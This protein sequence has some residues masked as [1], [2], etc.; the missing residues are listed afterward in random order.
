MVNIRQ[1]A[2]NIAHKFRMTPAGTPLA[3][4][5]FAL[6]FVAGWIGGF[7]H[8]SIEIK[9]RNAAARQAALVPNPKDFEDIRLLSERLEPRLK[10][11]TSALR[12]A[13]LLRNL[14]Y[15]RVAWSNQPGVRFTGFDWLD[16]ADTFRK[17]LLDPTYGHMCGGRAIQYLVALR[18]FGLSARKAAIYPKVVELVNPAMPTSHASV[19]VLIDGRWV[20]QDPTFNISLI[21]NSGTAIGWLEAARLVKIGEKIRFGTDGFPTQANRALDDFTKRNG[22]SLNDLT[23]HV[24]TSPFWD[25][26]KSQNGIK[27]PLDWDGHLRFTNGHDIP[28]FENDAT[29]IHDLLAQAPS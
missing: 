5:I 4:G 1:W 12:K 6:V 23:V 15:S 2:K 11:E 22:V 19:E 29:G 24:N 20:A 18:A 27:F 7:Q 21:D 28:V 3:A 25:G 8:R 14:I 26:T 13:Q 16:L 17:S 9:W 10:G